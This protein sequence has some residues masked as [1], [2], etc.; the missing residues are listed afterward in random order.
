MTVPNTEHFEM[1]EVAIGTP[2]TFY[3]NGMVE[4]TEPRIG[5]VVRLSRSG[6]N[7]VLRAAGG[8]YYESVRHI[9]DPKLLLNSDHRENGAWDF[10]EYHKSVEIASKML[11]KRLSRIE[12]VMNIGGPVAE[13]VVKE[14][15]LEPAETEVEISYKDLKDKAM[16]LGIEFKGNPKRQ[17]LEDQVSVLS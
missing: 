4:G 9:D 12:E 11:A 16:E 10:T 5:F 7:L 1:P 3:A 2:V 15:P 6:R 17:W 13:E 8:G 14:E